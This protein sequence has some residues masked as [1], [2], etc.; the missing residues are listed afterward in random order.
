MPWAA[1]A[2]RHWARPWAPVALAVG[3]AWLL[4]L[5]FL[6]RIA[7]PDEGGL[8]LV[9]GAWH[10]GGPELYGRLFVD[11]PPLLLLFFRLGHE[12]GGLLAVRVLGLAVIA[13]LVAAAGRV[14]WL[15]AGRRGATWAALVAAGL[16]SN[17]VLGALEV[18]GE[19][20]GASLVLGSGALALDAVRREDG[21]RSRLLLLAAGL[22]ASSAPLVK[23]NLVDGLV[24]VGVLVLATA[25]RD[26]WGLPRTAREVGA[27]GAGAVLPVV[28]T[29]VWALAW[30]P[31]LGVLW[32]TLVQFRLSAAEVI[33]SS[34]SSST[35]RRL[36]QLPMVALVSGLLPVLVVALWF[37]RRRRDD[38]VLVATVAL[39]LTE[40]AGALMGGNY[41][42]HYLIALVPAAALLTGLAARAGSHPRVMG[43]TVAAVVASAVVGGV[44]AL[45]PPVTRVSADETAVADWLRQASRPGDSGAV[46]YGRANILESAGLRPGYRQLWSLPVRTLD[47]RLRELSRSVRSPRGPVWLIEGTPLDTW[48]LDPGGR[49]Q[50]AVERHY[51]EVAT[52]CDI[53]VYLKRGATRDLPPVP[54]CS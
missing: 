48:G 14:G 2:R 39:L 22:L 21:R 10:A 42:T 34:S 37:A 13:L 36:V 28:A 5:P 25:W 46:T 11:R 27:L 52:V 1:A 49:V 12:L 54:D 17:P 7:Y 45:T 24:F 31:G 26:R 9:A 43:V 30:G 15:M 35:Q 18:N 8:L 23:Q 16:T 4:R 6:Q 29:C 20:I 47:P 51:R 40:V 3:L 38:P 41:W 53:A 32:E 50:R 19:L 33:A 44:V